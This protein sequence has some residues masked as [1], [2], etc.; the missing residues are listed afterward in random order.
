[1][2]RLAKA[3]APAQCNTA[4]DSWAELR[5]AIL[6]A[7]WPFKSPSYEPRLWPWLYGDAFGSSTP[8]SPRNVL[9]L[10]AVQQ[11][12]LQRWANGHACKVCR[13]RSTLLAHCNDQADVRLNKQDKTPENPLSTW[14]YGVYHGE[15]ER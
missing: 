5:R 14:A 10:P 2:P 1:M 8:T 12:M 9:D 7:F 3:P 15:T 13:R 6:N 4:A 11:V